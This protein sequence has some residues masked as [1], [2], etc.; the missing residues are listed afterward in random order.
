[1]F[2]EPVLSPNHRVATTA[3]ELGAMVKEMQAHPVRAFDF[4]TSGLR[5]WDG[6][7][8]IGVALGFLDVWNPD[9]EARC[10]YVPVRHLSMEPQADVDAAKRAFR[11]ALAGARSNVGHNLK[12]DLNMARADGW[13]VDPWVELHDTMVQAYLI[14][15]NRSLQL[16]RVVEDEGCSPY[17]DALEMKDEVSHWLEAQAKRHRM[18]KMDYLSANGHQEVPVSL[19]SEYACRDIG[20]TLALHRCQF[21]RAHN[22]NP[23]RPSLY[24]NEM[25]LVRALADMEYVGQPVDVDY[26]RR[27]AC[28]LDMELDAR[29]KDLVRLFGVNLEWNND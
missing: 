6:Q 7:R 27:I 11:D 26:L 16:E 14:N 29:N 8:P 25:L 1:M 23:Q 5:Y 3:D 24:Y 17:G 15:E 18:G 2:V 20:H 22:D 12:F 28:Q 9:A 4:E 19:E 13:H 21:D 10:W